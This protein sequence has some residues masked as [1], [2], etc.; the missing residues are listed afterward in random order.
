M[1]QPFSSIPVVYGGSVQH[2]HALTFLFGM[3]M[4]VPSICH[5]RAKCPWIDEA[6]AR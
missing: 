2:F 1:M 5:G 6:T 3:M 4:F